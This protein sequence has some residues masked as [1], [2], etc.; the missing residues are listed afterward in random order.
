MAQV[1][2]R[3]SGDDV[4]ARDLAVAASTLGGQTFN[5]VR[6]MGEALKTRVLAHASGRPGPR[7][8]TGDYKRSWSALTKIE[9]GSVTAEV[10][11]SAPQGPR[12]EYGFTGVDA[13]GRH[14]NQPPYPHARPALV[15]I[16]GPFEAA[17]LGMVGTWGRI[18]GGGR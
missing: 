6:T 2:I 14:Y 17:L 16:E 4:L 3:V 9:S 11:T 10:G 13:L 1:S 5:V 12:L 8:V 18:F 15:E 7:H